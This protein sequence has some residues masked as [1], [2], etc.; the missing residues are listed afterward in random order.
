MSKAIGLVFNGDR[1]TRDLF[2]ETDRVLVRM[3]YGYGH[4]SDTFNPAMTEVKAYSTQYLMRLVRE[5]IVRR[6]GYNDNYRAG[7]HVGIH[8]KDGETHIHYEYYVNGLLN[9]RH[10]TVSRMSPPYGKA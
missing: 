6:Y 1:V 9:R 3:E 5:D 10:W 2:P 7:N 8:V 4:R